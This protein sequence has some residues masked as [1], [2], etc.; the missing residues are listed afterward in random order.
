MTPW[1]EF[2]SENIDTVPESLGVFLLARGEGNISYV[3]RA[4]QNLRESLRAFLN[5][6]YSHFQ[7]VKV[8]WLKEAFEMQ[9]RLYHH[10][11]GRKRLDNKEHPFTNDPHY[12]LCQI[13]CVPVGMCEA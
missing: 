2:T 6:G 5:Q 13:A 1:K 11:G 10:E 7:W 3:G 12:S 4:D 9:C 8:P